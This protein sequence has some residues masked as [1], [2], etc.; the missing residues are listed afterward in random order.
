MQRFPL[1][2]IRARKT[3]FAIPL[4][5]FEKKRDELE[6]AGFVLEVIGNE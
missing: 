6:K 3:Y 1:R 5:L 2:F 4:W